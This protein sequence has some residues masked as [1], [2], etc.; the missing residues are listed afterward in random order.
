MDRIFQECIGLWHRKR[1]SHIEERFGTWKIV[2]T[3]KIYAFMELRD[4]DL[5]SVTNI[6]WLTLNQD[7][8]NREVN[9]S[10]NWIGETM[11]VWIRQGWNQ[12]HFFKHTNLE[13]SPLT[14]EKGRVKY[15]TL[16]KEF[17]DRLNLKRF[18]LAFRQIVLRE[19]CIV[20]D[21]LNRFLFSKS[22]QWD[23]GQSY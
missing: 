16:E 20:R 12:R 13:K 4:C 2:D 9:M 18:I 19:C 5:L 14:Q 3:S 10:A 8:K 11:F 17:K 7:F 1:V 22:V 6:D 21:W 23:R 15:E